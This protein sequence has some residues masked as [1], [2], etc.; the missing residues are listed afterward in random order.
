MRVYLGGE[1]IHLNIEGL[2]KKTR[3][4][5]PGLQ[6]TRLKKHLPREMKLLETNYLETEHLNGFDNYKYSSIDTSP[7]STYITHPFWEWCVKVSY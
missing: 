4:A 6:K 7:I 3:P 1:P 5:W 2:I